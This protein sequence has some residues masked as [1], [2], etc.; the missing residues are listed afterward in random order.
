MRVLALVLLSLL[1]FGCAT[2]RQ[3]A[4]NTTTQNDTNGSVANQTNGP[5]QNETAPNIT[6]SPQEKCVDSDDGD[7][8]TKGNVTLG[9]RVYV[10]VCTDGYHAKEYYCDG[11]MAAEKV[12]EYPE[13]CA[14]GMCIRPLV[15]C[16]DTDNGNDVYNA[17]TLKVIR[18]LTSA[19]YLDKCLDDSHLKEYYCTADGYESAVVNCAAGL[20]CIQAA[21]KKEACVD[22]DDYDIYVKGITSQ[23]SELKEDFCI[24]NGAGTE[25]YCENGSIAS[26]N[27]TCPSGHPCR[28]GRCG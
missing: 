28:E 19:E 24:D 18:D 1:L 3:Q 11:N 17:G 9:A 12:G 7:V 2:D 20:V 13:G 25:Y 10:D 5:V 21:C 14:D 27:F 15:T 6:I 16:T 26:R 22:G 4:N 23:G 8:Y